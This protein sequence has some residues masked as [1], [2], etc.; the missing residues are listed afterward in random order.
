M[1]LLDTGPLVA[2]LVDDEQHHDWATEQFSRHDGPLV[3]AEAV[4]SEAWFLLRRFPRHLRILRQMLADEVFNL[5]FHLEDEGAAV[6]VL[7]D[8]YGDVP[9]SLADACLVRL[10]ELHP[11]LPLLTLDSDFKVYRRHGRQLIPVV[12]P[13]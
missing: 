3:T 5:S 13:Q 6:S 10:S 1:V 2:Y 12:A 7:M 8:R 11:K 4:I 9:M